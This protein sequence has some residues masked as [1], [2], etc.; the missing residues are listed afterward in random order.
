MS[1]KYCPQCGAK[2]E[3]EAKFCTECGNRFPEE[4]FPP[5]SAAEPVQVPAAE[6]NTPAASADPAA[7]AQE[8]PSPAAEPVPVKKKKT[9]PV[10]VLA[11]LVLIVAAVA[12]M[13]FTGNMDKM[14]ATAKAGRGDYIGAF[15]SY[16]KYLSRSGDK[17]TEAYTQASLYALS[18]GDA[19]KA[20][21]YA[22]SVPEKSPEADGLAEKA[23]IVLAKDSI[24]NKDWR[25]AI[26]CLRGIGGDEAK[27]LADEA[28]YY[29]AVE[30]AEKKKFDEAIA[31]LENN[32]F[33]LSEDILG[34]YRYHYG[35]ALMNDGKYEEAVR[36]FEQTSFADSDDLRGECY[37]RTSVD[38]SFLSDLKDVCLE[39]I[40]EEASL[41]S[42]KAAAEKLSPYA[43]KLF[44]D[45]ELAFFADEMK[46]AFLGECEAEEK[47]GSVDYQDYQ[48]NLYKYFGLESE[49]LEIINEM[50]PFEK[51]DW[52]EISG[53]FESADRWNGYIFI[54][55]QISKDFS[56]ISDSKLES[57][58]QQYIELPNNTDYTVSIRVWFYDYDDNNELANKDEVTAVLP[59]HETTKI[60]FRADPNAGH[61]NYEF[62]VEDYE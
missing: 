16:E 36:Q 8:G 53:F 44:N 38:Y 55:D 25:G 42:V 51:E 35:V 14:I 21:M 30:A 19:D 6:Q 23:A 58:T 52:E 45:S 41:E 11:A 39:I 29:L 48:K 1:V 60:V 49:C 20:L 3:A 13:L 61:W 34:E 43:D 7:A 59:P 10:I 54:I 31:L 47:Y 32:T 12:I 26:E 57:E 56:G 22:R 28:N 2:N 5:T 46:N 33:E 27:K 37:F 24:A 62:S 18:A 4:T 50:Y 15:E 17:S 40:K 9:G